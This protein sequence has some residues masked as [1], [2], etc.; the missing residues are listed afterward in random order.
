MNYGK[1]I[2]WMGITLGAATSVGYGFAGDWRRC[3]YFFFGAC[4]TATVA[5]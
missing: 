3:L 2:A 5:W 1:I 4:I